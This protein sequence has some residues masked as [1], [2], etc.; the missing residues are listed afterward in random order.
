MGA[1]HLKA[2]SAIDG[3]EVGAIST[4][5]P[6]SLEGDLSHIRGNLGRETGVYD[7]SK[8]RKYQ[9]WRELLTDPELDAVDICLPTDLHVEASQIALKAG[10]HVLC[11]KPM[12]LSAEGCDQMIAAAK[13]NDR[14]LMIAQVLRFWPEYKFLEQFVRGGEYGR[15]KNATFV[16]RCGIPDWSKWLPHQE[17]SGGALLDLLVHD[18]DQILFL[19]GMPAKVAAKSLGEIDTVSATCLYD[20]GPEVRLQGGWFSPETPFAMGFQVRAEK[21]ELELTPDGLTLN[22]ESGQKK[23]S[24]EGPDGY[25]AETA[26]FVECCRSHK[27]PE[28]CLPEDSANA[29]RLALAMKKS[30][31]EGGKQI[32]CQS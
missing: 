22:A 20:G 24:P 16:R 5:N 13:D 15:I 4:S 28:R 6:R 31:D 23:I 11:E 26:Y 29:V 1:T 17:R 9:H 18:I 19:F 8:T 27:R 30:R 25:E 14:T 2:F 10:K 12:A 7:F 21:A 3:V 32:A